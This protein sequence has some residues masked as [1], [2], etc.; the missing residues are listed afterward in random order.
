[1]TAQA[2]AKLA[3]DAAAQHRRECGRAI[4]RTLK[5]SEH[6]AWDAKARKHDPI[7]LILASTY[8]RIA[9]LI[10]LKMARMA[11]SPFGFFRGSVP[12]FAADMAMTPDTGMQAQ[13][14]GDAHVHNLGAFAGPDG[15][16]VF[17]INDF[18][19]TIRGPFEWDLKRLAASLVLA[20]REA[21]NPDKTCARAVS[22]F[23]F[24]YRHRML[25]FLE[26][27][28]LEVMRYR[29][30]MPAT[31]GPGVAVL[32]KAERCTPQRSLEHLTV[33]HH[34]G[35]RAFRESPPLLTRV[36]GKRAK[37][38][39]ASLA[40]YRET[41]AP[42]RRHLFDFYRPVDV[43]FKVVGTGSVATHD[44]VV[45]FCGNG[46]RDPLFLQI[47]EEPPSAYAEFLQSPEN[48]IH[49][50]RRVVE[51][52]RR[53]QTQSDPL[54]GW[55]SCHGRQFMVR[56][57][58]DHKASIEDRDLSGRGLADYA[59][60]CAEVLAKAHARSGDPCMLAGYMGT[61][62]SF[63]EAIVKFALRYADQTSK[64]FREFKSAIRKGR[65]KTARSAY[66]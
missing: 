42:E 25:S 23:V 34:D 15:R 24:T 62:E 54:L 29:V 55:T 47:K 9:H 32:R 40:E 6:G 38:V 12:V 17:D 22:D 45:F 58:S 18:D 14:C 41:L 48:G 64:D 59:R 53:M 56:Q 36:T 44:Y 27:P 63:D 43:A 31:N 8:G 61:K 16:L 60:I 13:M 21:G 37:E 30:H 10:P 20:G 49:Q 2:A 7:D 4:R 35:V 28:M 3:R 66:L 39:L 1:M 65:I 57:L 26:M 19:E 33:R 46:V 51:G 52:Q 50:G 11:V 5:R